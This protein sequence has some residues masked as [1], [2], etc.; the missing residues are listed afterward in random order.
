MA[1]IWKF[2]QHFPYYIKQ[3]VNNCCAICCFTFCHWHSTQLKYI[4]DFHY[5]SERCFTIIFTTIVIYIYLCYFIRYFL[6]FFGKLYL[7]AHSQCRTRYL[8]SY[9]IQTKTHRLLHSLLVV[10]KRMHFISYH[11][12][13]FVMSN[14]Y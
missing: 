4:L 12:I 6:L 2:P 1:V 7:H 13:M 8:C 14:L 9:R 10:V 3:S 5:Y 11:S